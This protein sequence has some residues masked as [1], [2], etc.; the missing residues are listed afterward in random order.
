MLV[1]STLFLSSPLLAFQKSK[2]VNANPVVLLTRTTTKHEVRHFGYGGT[3][4]II[5]A[6]KGSITV[7]GWP[8]SEVEVTANI[9]L[10]AVASNVNVSNR[11]TSARPACLRVSV[12]ASVTPAS[13]R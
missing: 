6:P 13:V 9:E 11:S 10:L 5:G 2:T 1:V 12:R 3:V 4:T 7:E 8:R